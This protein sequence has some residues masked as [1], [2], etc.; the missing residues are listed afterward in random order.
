VNGRPAPFHR[1]GLAR[2]A[3]PFAGAMALALCTVALPPVDE[4]PIAVAVAAL[5]TAAI[6]AAVWL[7]PWERLPRD[8]AVG[9]P[10]AYF[11]VIVALREGGGAQAGYST[12]IALPVF[13][14]ALYGRR[15]ELGAALAGVAVTLLVPLV[16]VGAPLYPEAEIRRT[17]LWVAVAAIV[18]LTVQRLVTE[19]RESADESRRRA[20]ALREAQA[21]FR[22]AFDDAPIGC[23]LTDLDGRYLQVNRALADILGR[24]PEALLAGDFL[25]L[26]HSEERDAVALSRL[27]SGT[28]DRHELEK[29]Y[30]RPDGRSVWVQVTVSAVRGAGGQP[31]HLLAQVQ[32]VTERRRAREELARNARELEVRTAALER[33]NADL[34]QY[35][36]AAS[37][38]LSEPLRMVGSYV[39]LLERRYGDRLDD[40][41]REFIGYAVEGA[42]RMQALIDGLLAYS[43]VDT[44]SEAGARVDLEQAVRDA[45]VALEA[46]MAETGARVEVGTLPAVRGDVVQLRQL[47]QNLIANAVK[48]RSSAVP[49]I[50]ISA[51]PAPPGWHFLVQDNGIGIDARHRDRVFELFERLHARGAYGGAGIGLALCKRIVERH[52]GRIWVDEAPGGGSSFE[53]TLDGWADGRP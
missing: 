51:E 3:A 2:R 31:T 21:R 10:L 34:A 9:P 15:D 30:V 46:S 14:L 24:A 17:V 20:D 36:Y 18:G 27:S 35:A 33:S 23:A 29:R 52:G 22:S 26:T 12:L 48:F 50:R 28:A 32:D 16:V 4:Q 43:R 8:L 40:D 45:L 38:D 11:L 37:H 44:G 25:E 19:L 1:P 47:F 42:A 39:Q 13:W 5:L 49:E 41:G 6:G 53:F 7:L